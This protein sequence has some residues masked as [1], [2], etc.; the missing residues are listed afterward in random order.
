[1]MDDCLADLPSIAAIWHAK[2]PT[3][4]RQIPYDAM[5]YHGPTQNI[6]TDLLTKQL[7]VQIIATSHVFSPQKV[8]W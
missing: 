8:G 5:L 1:M 7:S 3:V 6:E 2:S 4:G